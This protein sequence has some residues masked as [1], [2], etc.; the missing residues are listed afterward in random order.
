MEGFTPAHFPRAHAAFFFVSFRWPMRTD[1]QLSEYYPNNGV[2]AVQS[3]IPTHLRI[4]CLCRWADER[5]RIAAPPSHSE[6]QPAGFGLTTERRVHRASPALLCRGRM[7]PCYLRIPGSFGRSVGWSIV[8]WFE[9][10]WQSTSASCS[11]NVASY[12]RCAHRQ[13]EPAVTLR[14]VMSHSANAHN[15]AAEC[16]RTSLDCQQTSGGV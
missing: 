9:V 8:P 4:R 2:L 11:G 5:Q 3:R 15:A 7:C 6:K 14:P 13:C 10:E 16:Q 12:E 1:R